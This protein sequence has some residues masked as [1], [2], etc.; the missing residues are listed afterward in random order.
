M[1][2]FRPSA[3]PKLS[4][5]PS[6]TGGVELRVDADIERWSRDLSFFQRE[7]V[8]FATALALSWTAKECVEQNR[9]VMRSVFDR[10]T[11]YTLRGVTMIGATKANLRARVE[12]TED[13]A[14]TTGFDAGISTGKYLKPQVFGGPRNPKRSELLLRA[15]GWMRADEFWVPAPGAALNAYGNISEGLMN[16]ILAQARGFQE[17]GYNANETARSR[18]RKKGRG[19][20]QR[21][22]VPREGH[23]LPRG[24]WERRGREVRPILFFVKQPTYKKLFP[25]FEVTRET[26]ELQLPIKWRMALARALGTARRRAA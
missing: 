14:I 9:R 3:Q 21:Y 26:A 16:K 6:G 23:P 12:F 22:F 7:Q 5:G 17:M 8:P 13:V 2:R 18:Q 24:V 11:P 19:E 25:F 15:V 10:P 4:T 20:T 1:S